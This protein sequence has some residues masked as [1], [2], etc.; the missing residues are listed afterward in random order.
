VTDR[1]TD[2]Q[3]R[4][5][6]DRSKMIKT[7][8]LPRRDWCNEGTLCDQDKGALRQSVSMQYTHVNNLVQFMVQWT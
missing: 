2:R 8:R 7:G 3:N 6:I 1:Q 4:V 5:V